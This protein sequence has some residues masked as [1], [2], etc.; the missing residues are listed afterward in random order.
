[1]P[2]LSEMTWTDLEGATA[3]L[4]VPVGAT[5]QHGPHLPLSTDTDIAAALAERLAAAADGVL[6]AP[7][8]AYGSS[9]EHQAFPGTISIGRE[10]L[11]HTLLELGRSATC[12]FPRVLFLSAHGG[13]T[14]AVRSAV[15]QLRDEGREVLAFS[16][17]TLWRGDSHAG[18][19]E[20]SVMLALDA[21]RVRSG[22]VQVGD[23]RPLS[24]LL[25]L[26]RRIGVAPLS[27]SGVLGDPTAA[28]PESG[29]WL[30]E[31]AIGYLVAAVQGWRARE[32]I[33]L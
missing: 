30:L 24:A 12:T 18:V 20:T 27:P 16:P 33:W 17:A 2:L 10:A 1:M 21:H 8:I 11:E 19:T 26:M 22:V 3:T 25:P 23:L 15:Q 5:E 7:A 13:N 9:G 28:S 4:V 14:D 29:T 31:Q 32:D 6:V